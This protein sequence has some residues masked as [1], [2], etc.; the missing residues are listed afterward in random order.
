[1]GRYLRA[2]DPNSSKKFYTKVLLR[3]GAKIIRKNVEP[4]KEDKKM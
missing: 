2:M 1:M 4:N 3:E